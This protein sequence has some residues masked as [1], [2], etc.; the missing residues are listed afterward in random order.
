MFGGFNF[1][2]FIKLVVFYFS[3]I[4][5]QYRTSMKN[6]VQVGFKLQI[7]NSSENP[8]EENINA[9]DTLNNRF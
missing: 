5:N 7:E 1:K 4:Q 6:P 8:Y 2:T 3:K 9:L